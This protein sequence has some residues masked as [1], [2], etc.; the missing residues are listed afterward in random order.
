MLEGGK[1]VAEPCASASWTAGRCRS[2]TTLGVDLG[3][4]DGSGRTESSSFHDCG[5]ADD[6]LG[7]IAQIT[8][9]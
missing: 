3:A 7:D 6:D 2:V 9:R 5:L 8:S 1:R 4:T